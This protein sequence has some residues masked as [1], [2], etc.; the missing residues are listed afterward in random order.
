MSTHSKLRWLTE[1]HDGSED[2]Q[3]YTVSV[4]NKSEGACQ[5][6]Q[7]HVLG[8]RSSSCKASHIQRYFVHPS[9]QNP[10]NLRLSSRHP[11]ALHQMPELCT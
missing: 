5:T 7:G 9:S 11:G 3:K 8:V 10:R 4:Q 2:E 1:G 6:L